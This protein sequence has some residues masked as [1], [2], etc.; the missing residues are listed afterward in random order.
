MVQPE[1]MFHT[2]FFNFSNEVWDG[3]SVLNKADDVD[4]HTDKDTLMSK[5][6]G[7]KS[8][9][10]PDKGWPWMLS[11]AEQRPFRIY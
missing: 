5:G 1:G 11:G 7:E 3:L 10:D 6:P 9:A 8:V 4:S 2:F